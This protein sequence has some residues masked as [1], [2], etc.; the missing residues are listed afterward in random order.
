MIR[1]FVQRFLLWR[2]PP[3]TD[4]VY[5]TDSFTYLAGRPFEHVLHG[6]KNKNGDTV[7]EAVYGRC[8]YRMTIRSYSMPYYVV[9]CEV[10]AAQRSTHDK[11]WA[12]RTQPRRI[13]KD[14]FIRMILSGE[15]K[16]YKE[17][18]YV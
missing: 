1:K 4:D 11:F 15:V 6:L 3:K 13:D 12:F 9:Q 2:N 8:T 7:A 14:V 18:E 5:W 16:K 10:L 17:G